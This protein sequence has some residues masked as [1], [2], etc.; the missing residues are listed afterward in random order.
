M[1]VLFVFLLFI[2]LWYVFFFLLN[3]MLFF[4]GNFFV[5][6]LVLIVFFFLYRYFLKFD[7]SVVLLFLERSL[8][9]YKLL[10]VE[11]WEGCKFLLILG[12]GF[13]WGRECV[14]CNFIRF[15][16]LIILF[17]LLL[18]SLFCFMVVLFGLNCSMFLLV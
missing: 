11:V 5:G 4:Y 2:C 1:N 17:Y 16:M 7:F 8:R 18:W 14:G 12:D 10:F 9:M 6:I 3:F 13:G 15:L